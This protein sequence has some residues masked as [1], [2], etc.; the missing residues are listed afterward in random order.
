MLAPR[1]TVFGWPN[2]PCSSPFL[3]SSATGRLAPISS[4]LVARQEHT[5]AHNTVTIDT[6]LLA[7]DVL[8]S[9]ASVHTRPR[10]VDFGYLD[11]DCKR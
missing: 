6:F 4:V 11:T 3:I 5:P 7:S 10:R 2:N 8:L 9:V 1:R